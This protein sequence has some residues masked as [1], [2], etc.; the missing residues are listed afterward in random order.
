MDKKSG[1]FERLGTEE[2]M[3]ELGALIDQAIDLA[4]TDLE[5]RRVAT[6]KEGIW[7]YMLEGRKE[8]LQKKASDNVKK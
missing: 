6:W 8:Y 3:N 4:E 1:N 5:K 7:D 2:R